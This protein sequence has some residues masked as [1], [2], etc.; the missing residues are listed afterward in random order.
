M[1]KVAIILGMISILVVNCFVVS[2]EVAA[3]KSIKEIRD[4]RKDIKS[5]LSEAE[6]KVADILMDIEE[7]NN[8]LHELEFLL[9]SNNEAMEEVESDISNVEEEIEKI[10]IKIEERFAILKNRAKSYQA[11]GGNISYLEVILNS[12]SFNDF[13]SRITTVSTIAN[14]DAELIEEQE[15]DKAVVEEKLEELE[16]LKGELETIEK[17]MNEQKESI[18]HKKENLDETKAKLSTLVDELKMKDKDL[19]KLENKIL[20]ES[21]SKDLKSSSGSSKALAG[22]I[23]GWPTNGGYIS[24]G[25][26]QRWGSMHKGIDIARTDRSTNPPIYAADSGTVESAGFNNGGYGNLV[27]I[28]H[29]NGMVTKYAHMS[30]INV[31]SGQKIEKGQQIGVMGSTGD[32]SGVHL[33]F[34]VYVNGNLQNP[35]N[36]LK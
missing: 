33:H 24:S 36:Y 16:D 18:L 12:T 29:G 14:S 8:E 30:S 6:K 32:S 7:L 22:G 2:N 21:V 25:L 5:D 35:I 28:N 3:E 10:E 23:L 20:S 4:E 17:N 26:G 9:E 15:R 13:L 34:E 11:S 1:K 31:T 19:Q 27:V